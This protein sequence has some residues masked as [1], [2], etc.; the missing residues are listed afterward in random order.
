MIASFQSEPVARHPSKRLGAPKPR[1]SVALPQTRRRNLCRRWKYRGAAVLENAVSV[2]DGKLDGERLTHAGLNEKELLHSLNYLDKDGL[3]AFPGIGEYLA[4]QIR[5][6]KKQVD[7]Y[8]ELEDLL[9]VP[10]FG[11]KRFINLVGREPRHSKLTIR[12]LM[13]YG[14]AQSDPITLDHFRPWPRP[15]SDVAEIWLLPAQEYFSHKAQFARFNHVLV[16]RVGSYRLIIACDVEQLQ[17]RAN[18][19]LRKLPKLIRSINYERSF[20]STN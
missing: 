1:A 17:G 20:T 19:L 9:E 7:Y 2:E 12:Q 8:S 16:E 13:R 11:A 15:A 6:H 3:L 14:G 5:K 18:Y 4:D 10:R